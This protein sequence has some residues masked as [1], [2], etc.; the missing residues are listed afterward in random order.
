MHAVYLLFN[1]I[2]MYDNVF[3]NTKLREREKRGEGHT[4]RSYVLLYQ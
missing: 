4:G 2:C 1:K 3:T